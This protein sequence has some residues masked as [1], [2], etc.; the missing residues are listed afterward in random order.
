MRSIINDL[1]DGIRTC[2]VQTK[3]NSD[4]AKR[5]V[6]VMLSDAKELERMMD[7]ITIE[8]SL[9]QY[10]S[11]EDILAAIRLLTRRRAA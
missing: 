7:D 4:C 9:P 3:N 11:E 8:L 6:G 1:I 10:A 2:V 5:C